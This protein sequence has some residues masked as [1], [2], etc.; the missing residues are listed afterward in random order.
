MSGLAGS[1]RSGVLIPLFCCPSTASWGIGDIGDVA[2]VARWLRDAGQQILQLLPLNEMASGK[3][4]PY[5]AMSAMAIDPI[6]IRV[7]DV[8]E[9]VALGGERALDERDRSELER[10]RRTAYVDYPSVRQLKGRAL[11]AAYDYFHEAEWAR[12]TA[13]A[14]AFKEFLASQAWWVE[15]YA[16]FRA[17]HAREDERSWT[18]WPEPLQRRD[19]DAIDRARRELTREVL[20]WQYL[21][22]IASTQWRDARAASRANGVELLGDLPF[23]VNGDSADVWARQQ[24]FRFDA[25]VGAPPD[26]FSA[27]GQ[28]WGVPVYRWD[29]V[30]RDDFRWLRSR[31]RRAADLYDGFRVDHLVGFYR[32]YARPRDGTEPFFTPGEEN[33]QLAL[34][35][36]LIS[37]FRELGSQVIA[38]DLGTVPPF[39][40]ASLARFGVPGFCVFRWERSWDA[41]GQPFRDPADYP[42]VSVAAS[43]THDTEPL[44]EWW[45]LAS[46]DERKLVSQLPTIQRIAKR[47]DLMEA[48]EQTA[49]D[50][51]LESLF[52]SKSALVL[53]PVTD[54]FSRRERI[55]DP[56]T[57]EG[58]NWTFRL[59]FPFDQIE[60]VPEACDRRDRL[61]SWARR[62]GRSS[63]KP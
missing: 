47:V 22:W 21:Q 52:A 37:V 30:A 41:A 11:A 28:D 63:A 55:N 35:E 54:I 13:R 12:G 61:R 53:L 33:A 25:T 2:D 4:S 5:S 46:E 19:P 58:M 48:D 10:V 14:S 24:E 49:S 62:H 32:T 20:H 29:A 39:V 3:H 36:R 43:S 9:F 44:V 59:P 27:T 15:D 16:L 40:R 34:G 26:A 50:V 60:H 57:L 45:E 51:L 38:E 18:D 1:R 17:I 31:V 7:T 6:F 8:P 42:R 56:S 23:M